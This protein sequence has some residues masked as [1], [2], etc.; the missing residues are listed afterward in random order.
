V[1]VCVQSFSPTPRR[2]SSRRRITAAGIAVLV[3]LAA[4]L[5]ARTVRAA[6]PTPAPGAAPMQPQALDI[7]KA[8]S[9]RLAAARSMTFT[10]VSTYESPSMAGVPLAYYSRS[11]VTLQRPDKLRVITTGDGPASE[12]YY[13]GKTMTAYAP[14]ENLVA[15]A[16]A[17]PTIDAALQTAFESAAVYF[18]FT[19]VLV[20]DPYKDIA[21]GLQVAYVI[22]RSQI[23]GNTTTDIIAL[24]NAKVFVQLWVGSA[25]HLPRQ[26]RAIY[27][28]DPA[29]LRQQV[30]FSDWK[31]DAKIPAGAFASA[32][33]AKA[34][35][36]R[37][38]RP[39]PQ[40]PPGAPGA[41]P[42]AAPATK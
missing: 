16:A 13:D 31:L 24:A 30:D 18:P 4:P 15:V 26:I 2:R 32:K 1:E 23:V 7:L 21:D 6:D 40:P 33:A 14:A 19:D 11:Q 25:D 22:G 37:F 17:P 34:A 12:F 5:C 27:I 10:A 41:T 20:A 36:I 28:N 39:D 38:A 9:A 35:P 29:Q 3:A 42:A 8:M